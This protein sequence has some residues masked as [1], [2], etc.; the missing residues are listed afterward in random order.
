M[1]AYNEDDYLNLAG[2]QHFSFCQRQWALIHIEK[3]W[4]ENLK[5]VEGE[6]LH[7]NA[8][9]GQAF[10]KRGD[11][12]VSRG[13]PVFSAT[14][15][16]NG[17]CDI[18]EFH[19]NAN[20]IQLFGREG[21][22]VPCPVEYKRGKPKESNMDTLQLTAQAMCLEEMLCCEVEE[23]YL[24]YGEIRHRERVLFTGALREE[25]R[26]DFDLMHQYY[27]RQYTPKVKFT[28]ACKSCSLKDLCIPNLDKCKS[29][30]EYITRKIEEDN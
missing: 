26:K 13:M 16:I 29:V 7:K 14:L 11:T 12:L 22:Y 27:E 23:G 5:T 28:K 6:L 4:K 19:R 30:K 2:I 10:E 25:V 8:H 18:V 3:L 9:D 17:I 20:G 1:K 21:K 24:Y 15:G